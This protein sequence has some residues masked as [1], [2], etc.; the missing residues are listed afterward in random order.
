[1]QNLITEAAWWHFT[2]QGLALVV[3]E[4]LGI[5]LES[6]ERG[7]R[8]LVLVVLAMRLLAAGGGGGGGGGGLT[9]DAADAAGDPWA[10]TNKKR[11]VRKLSFV[12]TSILAG[13]K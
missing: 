9:G 3:G 7:L 4:L 10:G 11:W 6:I 5:V 1:M 12:M 13:K 2:H 8:V